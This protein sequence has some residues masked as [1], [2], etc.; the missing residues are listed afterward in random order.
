M[1]GQLLGEHVLQEAR[2]L[3]LAGAIE[4]GALP[5]LL[6]TFD[7]PGAVAGLVLVAVAGKQAVPVLAEEEGEGVQGPGRA[8]PD[9]LVALGVDGGAELRPT[10]VADLTG[11]AVRGDDHVGAGEGRQ[12]RD[13][14]LE[15]QLDAEL[16]AALL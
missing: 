13:L 3:R 10:T 2:A 8:E 6:C 7:H 16:T 11:D 12:V 4:P 14:V 5:G 1:A 15:L 9:E